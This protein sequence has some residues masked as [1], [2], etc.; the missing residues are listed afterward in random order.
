MTPEPS[1]VCS[2]YLNSHAIY[3]KKE[4]DR[5]LVGGRGLR[6]WVLGLNFAFGDH[7]IVNVS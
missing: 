5:D 1:V 4:V 7:G 2:V 3:Q 6:G